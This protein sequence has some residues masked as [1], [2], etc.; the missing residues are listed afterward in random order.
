MA[1]KDVIQR[2]NLVI[3]YLRKRP[4]S[5]DDI[6]MYLENES[7]IQSADLFI[8]RRTFQRDI[9]EIEAI[10][11]IVIEFNRTTRKYEIVYD[12]DKP[13]DNML[14]ESFDIINTINAGEKLSE[15]ICFESR[16]ARGTHFILDI[17]TAI[18]NRKVLNI[19][20]QKY[21][22]DVYSE[23]EVEP[24]AIKEYKYRW[25][26]IAKDLK[27]HKIKSFGLD[28]IKALQST[29]SSFTYPEDFDIKEFF[30][31][32]YG[33]MG[34]EGEKEENIILSFTPF[35]GKF[36][37]AVPMHHSQRVLNDNKNE[38]RIALNLVP[39]VDF[40]MEVQ[41]YAQAVKVIQPQWLA[42]E[43]KSNLQE[44]LELY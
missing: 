18:K 29:H 32:T 33:I 37:K 38:F 8:S 10:W 42:D 1:Q 36:I 34:V 4:R 26:L 30:R 9:K 27:D 22:E 24:F 3:N 16:K 21:W 23:R 17:I 20:H 43:I 13:E 12:P 7:S 5:F 35:Q 41:Q 40:V 14:L 39:T 6:E 25:Y 11:K 31:F 15:Y 2:Q 28:R 19:K 44:T